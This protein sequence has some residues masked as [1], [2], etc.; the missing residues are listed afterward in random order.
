M[1]GIDVISGVIVA[2]EI[3]ISFCLAGAKVRQKSRNLQKISG[4]FFKYVDYFIFQM[5]NQLFY[6]FFRTY[7][8]PFWMYGPAGFFV[9]IPERSNLSSEDRES[10][11]IEATLLGQLCLTKQ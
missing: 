9:F 2:L 1:P 7:F 10:R 8:F 11:G 6:Y 5:P 3:S 4:L